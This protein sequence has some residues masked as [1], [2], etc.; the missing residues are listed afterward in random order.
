VT[1]AEHV[2]PKRAPIL[3]W[4]CGDDT[5]AGFDTVNVRGVPQ[6]VHRSGDAT[7]VPRLVP[8]PKEGR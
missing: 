5:S 7:C 2:L 1:R 4:R 8:R 6:P 3:C